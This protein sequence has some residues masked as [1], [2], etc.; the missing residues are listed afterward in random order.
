MIGCK[1]FRSYALALL[2]IAIGSLLACGGDDAPAVDVEAPA[3]IATSEALARKFADPAVRALIRQ[4]TVE[5]ESYLPPDESVSRGD[6]ARLAHPESI[7]DTPAIPGLAAP[8][9]CGD[10]DRWQG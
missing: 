9:G 3:R 10:F 5:P 7:P 1:G 4:E 2:C 6:L 8:I